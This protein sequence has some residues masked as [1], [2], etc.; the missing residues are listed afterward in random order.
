MQLHSSL[1][2]LQS[3]PKVNTGADVWNPFVPLMAIDT[4]SADDSR[5]I[6][7]ILV[8]Y[9]SLLVNWCEVCASAAGWKTKL[10]KQLKWLICRQVQQQQPIGWKHSFDSCC[11]RYPSRKNQWISDFTTSRRHPKKCEAHDDV[12]HGRGDRVAKDRISSESG[13]FW[14]GTT[15][16]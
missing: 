7:T 11:Y 14:R 15:A 16:S 2:P 8:V 3:H 4:N 12:K 10:S 13:I 1:E 5:L 6:F 9:C